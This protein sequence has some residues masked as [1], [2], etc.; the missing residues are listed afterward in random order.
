MAR[1]I[2]IV[3]DGVGV[4]HLPDAWEYGDNGACTAGHVIADN[5]PSLP[6]MRAIGFG[7]IPNTGLSE[8]K[9][10]IGVYGRAIETSKGKDTTTG[11]WE[12]AGLKLPVPF[13][14]YPNGFPHEIIK[15]FERVIGMQ[16]LGNYASSGTAILNDLGQEHVLTG[17]PIVYTSAD[18][19]FQIACHEGVH[20]INTLYDM[21][22]VAR[23][24]L[25]KQHQVGRVIARPFIG[26]FGSFQRTNNR[27]DFSLDPVG[28]TLLDEVSGAGMAM[29]AVGKIEDIFNMRG[30][31]ESNHASGNNACIQATLDFL[32]R[33]F[34]GMIFTN[35]VDFDMLY[36]HRNDSAGFAK[37]LEAFDTQIPTILHR[38]RDDDLLI[39]TADHGC[40]PTFPGTDHT[41]EFVPILAQRK[42]MKKLINIGTRESFADIAATVSDHLGLPYRFGAQ[43]F[44]RECFIA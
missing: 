13:P 36:G 14:T 28:R 29:L 1:A 42:G 11:H 2:I 30:I 25:V 10:A 3:L 41:R 22:R 6:N 38:M 17:K 32:E 43:S 9:N 39:I 18:S 33:D 31:T 23:A 16:V 8:S 26:T 19:V 5:A 12:I 44:L 4:G 40:D 37:A 20:N 34:S 21:C 15:A 27:R 7:S 24:L 35:L